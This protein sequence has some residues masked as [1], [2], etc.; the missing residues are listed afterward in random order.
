MSDSLQIIHRAVWDCRKC[1]GILNN[2]QILPRSGF[3]TNGEYQAMVVGAEPG[4]R[5]LS[6]G[7]PTPEQ[8]RALFAPGARNTNKARL[9]FEYLQRAGVD[10]DQ[11]F[12]TNSVKCPAQ[13]GAQSR[14]CWINCQ[15]YLQRQM[16][17]I[18]PK[19][20]V[21]M[22]NAAANLGFSKASKGEFYKTELFGFPIL[23]MTHPQGATT[24]YMN[25]VSEEIGGCLS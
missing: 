22:G 8:Y 1:A 17:V 7:R 10:W 20:V 14:R 6:V 4:Q 13:A 19:I 21:V 5:A 16:Q 2:E 23:V 24:E 25:R 11:F 9:I 15:D 18:C 3:P 12:Y